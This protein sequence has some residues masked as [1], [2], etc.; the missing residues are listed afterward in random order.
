MRKS[1]VLTAFVVLFLFSETAFADY[2]ITGRWLLEGGG[3]AEKGVLRVELTDEG[4]LDIRTETVNGVRCILGYS[5]LFRLNASKLNINAW[6]YKKTV[7]LEYPV[8][9]PSLHPTA[10]E[11]FELL[12]VTVDNLTYKVVFTSITSGTVDIYGDLN[13]DYVGAV[14]IDSTSVI[15][16]EGTQKPDI[17]DKSSGCNAGMAGMAWMILALAPLK[18]FSRA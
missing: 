15:W 11:P 5:V 18:G 9:L 4:Y 14:G 17:S 10:N 7:D 3:H 12:P 16:K 1:I 13:V 2:D 6:E 8:P